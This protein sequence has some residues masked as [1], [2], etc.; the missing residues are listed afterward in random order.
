MIDGSE[1][2]GGEV[3]VTEEQIAQ[4]LGGLVPADKKA[5][6]AR[7]V[8]HMI[9]RVHQGPLPAPDDFAGYE[10]VLPGSADRIV[11][12][13][14]REQAHRHKMEGR[15]VLGEYGIRFA[16]QFAAVFALLVLACLIAFCAYD[17]FQLQE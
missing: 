15:M 10:H 17:Q 4:E 11:G 5:A 7:K 6:V 16:G 14:E 9:R 8:T 13:T 3:E 12:L 2:F 1:G